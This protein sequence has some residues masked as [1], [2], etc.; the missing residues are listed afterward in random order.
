V[1]LRPAGSGPCFL[2]IEEAVDRIENGLGRRYRRVAAADDRASHQ[3]L[4]VLVH[5]GKGDLEVAEIG[6]GD[7]RKI[8]AKLGR[9]VADRSQSCL[10]DESMPVTGSTIALNPTS[11][12]IV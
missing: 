7:R 1:H 11:I 8:E 2:A 12:L 9:K 5:L 3:L 4:A 6:G 10:P